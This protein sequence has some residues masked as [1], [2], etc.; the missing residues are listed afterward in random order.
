LA[1]Q[2]LSEAVDTTF[3]RGL[4]ATQED[5][6]RKPH[7]FIASSGRAIP[8]A[9]RLQKLLKESTRFDQVWLWSEGAGD[10][11][12]QTITQILQ[13]NAIKC[14]F[15]AVVLTGDDFRRKDGSEC[16]VPRDN[17]IFEAGL[18]IGALGVSFE[19]CFLICSVDQ[20]ALPSD[21]HAP[22]RLFFTEPNPPTDDACDL[23]VKPL[24]DK[25]LDKVE[26]KGIFNRPEVPFITEAELMDLECNLSQGAVVVSTVQPTEKIPNFAKRIMLNMKNDVDY[27]YFL[28]VAPE[29]TKPIV[30]MVQMLSLVDLRR[31]D[32][33]F[34]PEETL[35]L[36][37]SNRD[38]FERNLNTLQAHLSIHFL[39]SEVPTAFCV[40]NA[41]APQAAKC[42]LLHS[43]DRF[44][45]WHAA[46]PGLAKAMADE[47][48]NHH[49]LDCDE[50][51]IFHSTRGFNLADPQNK[52][53]QR[54]LEKGIEKYFHADVCKKVK[55][56][57][58]G[59][60]SISPAL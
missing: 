52:R 26:A 10:W 46:T 24:I 53:F 50:D 12:G 5:R 39:P 17:C 13:D 32:G 30:T 6:M 55:E 35:E 43:S 58:F 57:C 44:T 33:S 21:L 48:R 40:H 37:K 25:I 14:D 11:L 29:A 22:Q 38:G 7:I 42:Y 15:A 54:N 19:R 60:S 56:I 51:T 9:H 3:G 20:A 41:L 47:L 8:V 45:E 16:L 27:F 49:Y 18:F 23:V 59:K 36:M 2:R 4:A 28:R 1:Q 31:D 34:A